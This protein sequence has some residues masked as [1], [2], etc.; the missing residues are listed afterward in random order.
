MFM[1]LSE[2]YILERLDQT[3]SVRGFFIA[4]VELVDIAI[5]TLIQRIFRKDD[6]AVQ[7]VVG[8]LLQDSGPLGTLNVR[9]KLLFGLGVIPNAIYH[10]IE[11]LILIRNTLNQDI[12]D[13]ALTDTFILEL[14][15]P[16]SLLE[17]IELRPLTVMESY[18]DTEWAELQQLQQQKRLHSALSLMMVNI[19]EQLDK[20]SPF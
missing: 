9:L 16:L 20:H 6:F 11:T 15:R 1:S 2:H 5:D 19:C 7:S 10:D 13:Y 14:I 12:N 18:D 17:D 4:A 3:P 8:P